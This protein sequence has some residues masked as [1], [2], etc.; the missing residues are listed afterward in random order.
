MKA[1]NP[2]EARTA[3]SDAARESGRQ[4]GEPGE[5]ELILSPSTTVAVGSLVGLTFVY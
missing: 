2:L 3:R 1:D 4:E 5:L